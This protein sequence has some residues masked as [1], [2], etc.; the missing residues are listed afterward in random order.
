M[1]VSEMQGGGGTPCLIR[2]FFFLLTHSLYISSIYLLQ[3][4]NLFL[5]LNASSLNTES[6]LRFNRIII[7]INLFSKRGSGRKDVVVSDG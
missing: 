1:I 7:P 3:E 6:I 2:F 5:R 4:L